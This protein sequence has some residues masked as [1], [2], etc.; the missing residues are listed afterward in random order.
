MT[1]PVSTLVRWEG[2]QALKGGQVPE[3][4]ERSRERKTHSLLKHYLASPYSSSHH[5]AALCIAW[6]LRPPRAVHITTSSP[7][8]APGEK[9]K[10][11]ELKHVQVFGGSKA[12]GEDGGVVVGRAESSQVSD[13]AA[14]DPCRLSQNIPGKEH[15]GRKRGSVCNQEK[16]AGWSLSQDKQTCSLGLGDMRS[17]VH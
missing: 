12:S 8:T 2:A 7:S 5:R 6:T 10:T 9:Q 1:R 3:G 4:S 15:R 11:P 17:H 13:L 14:G 16:G